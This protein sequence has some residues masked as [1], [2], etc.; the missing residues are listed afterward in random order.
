M[1]VKVVPPR[2]RHTARPLIFVFANG[3]SDADG[4]SDGGKSTRGRPRAAADAGRGLSLSRRLPLVDQDGAAARRWRGV[5]RG[6][7]HLRPVS[8]IPSATAKGRPQ[9]QPAAPQ[10]PHSP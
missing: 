1:A 7:A 4:L 2:L 5:V 9:P 10:P 3:A 8:L 6:H